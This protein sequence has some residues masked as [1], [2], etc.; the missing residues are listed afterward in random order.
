MTPSPRNGLCPSASGVPCSRAVAV[1]K[2][3][4]GAA[5]VFWLLRLPEDERAP[6][7][8]EEMWGGE[9]TQRRSAFPVLRGAPA[10][11]ARSSAAV[12]LGQGAWPNAST[13]TAA[14]VECGGDSCMREHTRAHA[15]ERAVSATALDLGYRR[16]YSVAI[17]LRSPPSSLKCLRGRTARA[18]AFGSS[19]ACFPSPPPGYASLQ[20]A[21][22]FGVH[23]VCGWPGWRAFSGALCV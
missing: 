19:P 7:T 21:V 9:D 23:V 4:R 11:F 18:R 2:M 20:R 13:A 8:W 14:A 16:D 12:S 5:P 6:L 15:D 1:R 22:A 17:T 10:A 3:R